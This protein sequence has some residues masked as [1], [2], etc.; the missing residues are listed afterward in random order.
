MKKKRL[1][2]KI[3]KILLKNLNKRFPIIFVFFFGEGNKKAQ[4]QCF[5][6]LF[7]YMRISNK[8]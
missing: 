5:L 8:K 4:K 7:Q 6:S 3:V 1:Q 2:V